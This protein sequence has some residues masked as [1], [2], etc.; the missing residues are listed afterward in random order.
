MFLEDAFGVE[1]GLIALREL[2]AGV[3]GLIRSATGPAA[4]FA[5]GVS[6]MCCGS[7]WAIAGALRCG[8]GCCFGRGQ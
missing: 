6:A 7:G 2:D 8:G 3:R 5:R 1:H 4:H